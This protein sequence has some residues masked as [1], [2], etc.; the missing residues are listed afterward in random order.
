ME[1]EHNTQGQAVG[2]FWSNILAYTSISRREL[3]SIKRNDPEGRLV[4][5]RREREGVRD[6]TEW[7]KKGN[8]ARTV[9]SDVTEDV[10]LHWHY[11]H[12][13]YWKNCILRAKFHM[14]AAVPLLL[15]TQD[16]RGEL[17]RFFGRFKYR[18]LER[19]KEEDEKYRINPGRSLQNRSG[20]ETG[21]RSLL[22]P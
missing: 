4:W 1:Q 8:M 5:I 18:S 17:G 15:Y 19:M 21:R 20:S 9:N 13:R 10:M 7:E 22:S 2:C 11:T 3:A 16:S 14:A 6:E 12:P